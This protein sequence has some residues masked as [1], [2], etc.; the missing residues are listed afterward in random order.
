MGGVSCTGSRN[1]RVCNESRHALAHAAA[2]RRQ[3]RV[4]PRERGSRHGQAV[5]LRRGRVL[6][7]R[8]NHRSPRDGRF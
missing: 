7:E 1:A 6:R 4:R 2:A 3:L 5:L 8:L